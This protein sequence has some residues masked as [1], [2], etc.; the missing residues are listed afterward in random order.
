[1]KVIIYGYK[2]KDDAEYTFIAS[3]FEA[4]MDNG[5]NPFI[6]KHFQKELSQH[7]SIYKSLR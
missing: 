5:I 7:S 2:I 4:M 6:F 1:M 3:L